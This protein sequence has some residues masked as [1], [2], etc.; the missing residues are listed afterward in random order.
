MLEGVR[1]KSLIRHF[2][3][4]G[5]FSEVMRR[6]WGD[7]LEEPEFVQANISFTYP[8][9]VRAWHRHLKGQIDYFICLRGSI[10]ICAYDDK[11]GELNEIISAGDDSKIVRVP[12]YYWHGFKVVG[13]E[14]ALLL[15]FVN[16][17][18]D[19]TDPDEERR[20]W[21]DKTILPLTINGKKDDARTGKP[22]DW[23][24]PPHK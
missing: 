6:D 12:G 16:R 7:I 1:I 3:E 20:V 24:F 11:T 5:F 4:R 17:L 13:N 21:D 2:D 19:Y 9:I 10:M 8:G 15:Y 23:F 22:W 18:Y 14:P